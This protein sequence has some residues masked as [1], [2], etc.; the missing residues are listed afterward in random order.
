MIELQI[1]KMEMEELE[2]IWEIL[3]EIWNWKT[4]TSGSAYVQDVSAVNNRWNRRQLTAEEN[5]GS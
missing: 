2:I 3:E 1:V 5:F 4:D